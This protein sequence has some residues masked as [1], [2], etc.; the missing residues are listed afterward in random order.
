MFVIIIVRFIL[1]A[2][3]L[4]ERRYL[5]EIRE[6]STAS[7]FKSIYYLIM[8]NQLLLYI[9]WLLL[10][11]LLLVV[12]VAFFFV[13]VKEIKLEL[14]QILYCLFFWDCVLCWSR[15][16]VT[17]LLCIV[18]K[19]FIITIFLFSL[20]WCFSSRWRMNFRSVSV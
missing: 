14:I 9:W 5:Y 12:L 15:S 19:S 6:S 13:P 1:Y 17:T 16:D 10:T 2:Y 7:I 4:T 3:V 20:M 8:I 18:V 11:T